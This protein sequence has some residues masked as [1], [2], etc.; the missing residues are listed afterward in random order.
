MVNDP[1]GSRSKHALSTKGDGVAQPAG[2]NF[3]SLFEWQPFNTSHQI[4]EGPDRQLRVKGKEAG[5][6]RF[7]HRQVCHCLELEVELSLRGVQER[8]TTTIPFYCVG[9]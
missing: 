5:A 3:W 2:P 1:S 6:G 7:Q 9:V 4:W 8:V